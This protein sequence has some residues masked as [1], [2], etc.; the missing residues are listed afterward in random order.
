MS[1]TRTMRIIVVAVPV[2]L[3]ACTSD[4]VSP[5]ASEASA[6]WQPRPPVFNAGCQGSNAFQL[7][8][9]RVTFRQPQLQRVL[10]YGAPMQ[11][12]YR[13]YGD[14]EMYGGVTQTFTYDRDM[15]DQCSFGTGQT[16]QVAGA[17]TDDTL[18][19]P[20]T[21]PDGIAQDLWDAIT[22]RVRKQLREAAW[23]LA[24]HWVPN[25]LP[26]VG[27]VI[28]ETRRGMIFSALAKGYV[29]SLQR[30]PDRRSETL[31]WHSTSWRNGA[32]LSTPESLRLDALIIGCSTVLQFRELRS[33]LPSQAE[34]WASR[35]AAAWAADRTQGF[36]DRY[37]ESQLARL[38]AI[39]AQMGR[40][41][42]TCGQAARYHFENR[43]TDLYDPA[44]PGSPDAFQF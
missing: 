35:L 15:L 20:D 39:G 13:G 40:E 42:T 27:S 22:P 26:G 18:D 29:N 43:P 7:R 36:A 23:Y 8:A 19:V 4:S 44:Q 25:D 2:G 24:D 34:E 31:A 6:D 28:R 17:V 5:V 41:G 10:V 32:R 9:R 38:G 1:F 3:A 21:A 30:T 33:W 14:S 37:L 11:R 12:P 16:F